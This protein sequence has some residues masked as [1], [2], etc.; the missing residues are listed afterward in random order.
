M[1]YKINPDSDKSEW[2]LDMVEEALRN[3]YERKEEGDSTYD[4]ELVLYEMNGNDRRW[5]MSP[6]FFKEHFNVIDE[7]IASWEKEL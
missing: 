4:G 6:D 2:D 3:T 7:K 5:H 1:K